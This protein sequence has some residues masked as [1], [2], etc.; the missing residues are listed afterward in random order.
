MFFSLRSPLGLVLLLALSVTGCKNE[1][2]D[3]TAAGLKAAAVV[4]GVAISQQAVAAAAPD[5]DADGRL[6]QLDL[7]VGQQVLANAAV[8]DK[9]DQDGKVQAALET[10][11]RQILARAYVSKL[12][13]AL[14]KP[15]DAEIKDY[16]DKHPELFSKRRIYRLL[17]LSIA[18]APERVDVVTG[19][20]KSL[21]TMEERTSWLKGADIPFS[22]GMSAKAAEEVPTELLAKLAKLKQGDELNLPAPKGLVVA[23]VLNA[24]E[25]PLTFEQSQSQ[26]A[27]FLSNTR[28]TEAIE[29]ET[30]RLRGGAKTE[31]VA[32]Y[33]APKPKA[34]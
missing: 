28:V 7:F 22:M 14:P 1:G 31:Y 5:A 32:P 17:E 30:Q 11:K 10:A 23:H 4:D 26:I 8:S 16:F 25:K 33:A 34:G 21:K 27:R 19:K 15:T 18:V 9:L 2:A 24:E 12:A 20:F 6:R 13:Q 3:N 29:K